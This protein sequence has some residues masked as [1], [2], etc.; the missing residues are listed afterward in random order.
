MT[1]DA[2]EAGRPDRALF[3]QPRLGRDQGSGPHLAGAHPA[4]FLLATS[5]LSSSTGMCLS[6][7]GMAMVSGANNA[8]TAAGRRVSCITMARRVGS[9][10]A[11]KTRSSGSSWLAIW[12]TMYDPKIG[13]RITELDG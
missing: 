3:R 8:L 1:R 5:P 12:L 11:W 7:V 6:S 13:V 10:R 2:G 4:V 9:D